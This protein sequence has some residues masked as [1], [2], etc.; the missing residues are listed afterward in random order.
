MVS[1]N[2][3]TQKQVFTLFLD[4]LSEFSRSMMVA[5]AAPGPRDHRGA[6][7]GPTTC[8][9]ALAKGGQAFASINLLLSSRGTDLGADFIGAASGGGIIPGAFAG[10]GNA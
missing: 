1:P 4:V 5:R 7:G 6:T 10:G 9:Q 8:G 2:D 3:D